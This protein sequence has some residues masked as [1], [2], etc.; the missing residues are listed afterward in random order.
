MHTPNVTLATSVLKILFLVSLKLKFNW[1]SCI[2]SGDPISWA[3]RIVNAGGFL[4][5]YRKRNLLSSKRDDRYTNKRKLKVIHPG[6][7]EQCKMVTEKIEWECGCE[8]DVKGFEMECECN[9]ELW[10]SSP[11]FVHWRWGS[12]CSGSVHVS[13]TII[14]PLFI[15]TCADK[16]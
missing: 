7:K 6:R 8:S 1:M 12:H 3:L 14:F 11:C 15:H 4:W 13:P 2:L 9:K 16:S 5:G 10:A